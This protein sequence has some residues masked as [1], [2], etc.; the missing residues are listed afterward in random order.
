MRVRLLFGKLFPAA[1]SAAFA[2]Y[3][4]VKLG[5]L[6]VRH[7]HELLELILKALLRRFGRCGGGLRRRTAKR[8]L[9]SLRP[10]RLRQR[11]LHGEVDFPSGVM[12]RIF[13]DT[14]CPSDRKSCTSFTKVGATSEMCTRPDFPSGRATNAP[15]FV[16]VVT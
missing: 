3:V 2:G 7:G 16:M 14:S 10:L 15:N 4:A 1:A 5:L 9:P 12:P 6:A 11:L 8:L 13:T